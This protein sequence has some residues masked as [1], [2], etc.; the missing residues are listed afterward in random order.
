MKFD[1]STIIIRPRIT[2][3]AAVLSEAGNV[4]TFEVTRAATKTTI[5]RAIKEVYKVA[6]TRVNIVKLPAK[7]VLVKGK[8]GSTKAVVKAYVHLKKGDKIDLA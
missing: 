6:P 4:Y 8:K 3:K 1:P 2:E 7:N 5:K